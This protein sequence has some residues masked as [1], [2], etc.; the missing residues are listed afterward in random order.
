MRSTSS[1]FVP[2]IQLG[3]GFLWTNHRFPLLGNDD[4]VFNF[5][6]EA[7]FGERYFVRR[8]QSLDFAI[9]AA[10]VSNAGLA[11]NTPTLVT[12]QFSVGYSWWK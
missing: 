7:G 10:N 11:N 9:K 3:N 2:F 8:S 12:L 4:G 6:P 5:T 1:R